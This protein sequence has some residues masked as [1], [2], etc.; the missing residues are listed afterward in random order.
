MTNK[1]YVAALKKLGLTHAS[2]EAA[3]VRH[4]PPTV[5]AFGGRRAAS[6]EADREAPGAAHSPRH[7][8]GVAA[9]LIFS[10][11]RDRFAGAMIAFRE[12]TRPIGEDFAR[13]ISYGDM[14]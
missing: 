5:T 14:P 11:Q 4:Y 7:P 9:W 13:P 10:G 2:Q 6:V 3:N 8:G 1:Q 12:A